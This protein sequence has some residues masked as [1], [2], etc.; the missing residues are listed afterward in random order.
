MDFW[1]GEWEEGGKYDGR[2]E[3]EVRSWKREVGSTKLEGRS[4]KGEV[5]STKLEE[6]VVKIMLLTQ[7][8]KNPKELQ[9]LSSSKNV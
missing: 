8:I 2:S 5:G 1:E 6:R 9:G 7:Q 4:G 3:V